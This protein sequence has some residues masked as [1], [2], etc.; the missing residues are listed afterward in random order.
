MEKWYTQVVFGI[1]LKQKYSFYECDNSLIHGMLFF[2]MSSTDSR[3][4]TLT[5]YTVTT[6]KWSQTLEKYNARK[7]SS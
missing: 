4:I 2:L 5:T 7:N 1:S 3:H 6:K